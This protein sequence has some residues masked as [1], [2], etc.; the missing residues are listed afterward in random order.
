MT[1][2]QTNLTGVPY[3]PAN[4]LGPHRDITQMIVM[5]ATGNPND[6][7]ASAFDEV[8]YAARNPEGTS[9]HLTVDATSCYQS[10]PLDRVAYGC[11]PTGNARSL[12]VEQVSH[13][14]DSPTRPVWMNAAKYVAR[15]VKLYNIPIV[16]LSPADLRAG[17]RG[18]CGHVD[19]TNAWGEG[20]HT[21]PGPAFPWAMFLAEVQHQYFLL[22]DTVPTPTTT[23]TTVKLK[24]LSGVQLD[25]VGRKTIELIERVLPDPLLSRMYVTSNF[26]PGDPGYHGATDDHGALD[27]A[28]PMTA[29]GERDMRDASV[30]MYRYFADMTE[31]IHT[32]PYST[33]NGFYVKNGQK[34]GPGYYGAQT[35]AEHRNHI[36]LAFTEGQLDRLL[37]VVP[38]K[39]APRTPVVRAEL[40]P[41]LASAA[42]LSGALGT[43]LATL[44]AE[45]TKLVAAATV[46]LKRLG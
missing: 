9:A 16:K 37:R 17:K 46:V 33:D 45:L 25:S 15:L 19:V 1:D 2:S 30:L 21:D 29:A 31:M 13:D 8:Q 5:H 18:I 44:K 43:S 35:E 7:P 3:V 10:V 39:P 36:H 38:K 34:V 32:T 4:G 24:V 28:A 27:F 23:E 11:F 20:D 42:K 40:D 12:Q 22:V 14:H 26:R 6:P 41:V